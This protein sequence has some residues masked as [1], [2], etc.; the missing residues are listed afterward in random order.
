MSVVGPRPTQLEHDDPLP[1]SGR[2]PISNRYRIKPGIT[3]GHRSTVFRGETDRI[4]KMERRVANRPVL[5]GHMVVRARHA[6]Y[7]RER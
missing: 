7:R 3:G 4:E 2:G 5:P 1:E 6:D